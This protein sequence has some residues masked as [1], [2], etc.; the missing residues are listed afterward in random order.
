[1]SLHDPRRRK[2]VAA[3]ASLPLIASGMSRDGDS[4]STSTTRF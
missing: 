2:V 1:M 3:I 4:A